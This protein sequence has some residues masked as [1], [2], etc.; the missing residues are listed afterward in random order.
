M[1]VVTLTLFQTGGFTR[2]MRASM[3]ETLRMDHVRTAR[4]KGAG[5]RRVVLVHAFRNALIPVVT[6]MALNFGTLFGG[7]L[8]TETM[9]AHPG[10]GKMIYDSILGNDYNL[11]LAGLLFATLI[12]LLSQPRRGHCLWLARSADHRRNERHLPFPSGAPATE[13][14]VGVW[15]LRWRRF[16]RHRAGM[17][18]LLVLVLLMP[19]LARRLS[20]WSGSAASIPTRP[21]CCR[22]STRPRPRTGWAPTR[23]GATNWSG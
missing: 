9:F 4:A 23:P 15:R 19:V 12:T 17:A 5:E 14:A 2:F 18:A 16:R 8:L 7:A 21:T 11:A 10:M 6:V 20:R 3:I 1:P 13:A 22:A